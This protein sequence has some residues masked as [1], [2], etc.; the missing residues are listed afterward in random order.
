MS[1]PLAVVLAASSSGEDNDA[2]IV[3]GYESTWRVLPSSRTMLND[4][5]LGAGNE[6]WPRTPSPKSEDI[7]LNCD[8]LAYLIDQVIV[9]EQP[10]FYSHVPSMC[11]NTLKLDVDGLVQG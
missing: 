10:C 3:M 11:Q 5:V 1:P 7:S 4:E 6:L 8:I 9:V 2:E